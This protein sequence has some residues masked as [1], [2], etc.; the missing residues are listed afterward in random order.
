M[1]RIISHYTLKDDKTESVIK[2]PRKHDHIVK[3]AIFENDETLIPNGEPEPVD[4]PMYE[5]EP[6]PLPEPEVVVEEEISVIEELVIPEEPIEPVLQLIR[7]GDGIVIG[8]EVQC[9][10]GEKIIIKMEY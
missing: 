8:I 4:E 7:N 10:C 1:A 5:S 9:S 2:L 6:E 3:V